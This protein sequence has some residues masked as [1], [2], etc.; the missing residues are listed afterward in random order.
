MVDDL[1]GLAMRKMET[2]ATIAY[3]MVFAW[4]VTDDVLFHRVMLEGNPNRWLEYLGH[5]GD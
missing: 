3:G 4:L 1:E 2:S 5:V